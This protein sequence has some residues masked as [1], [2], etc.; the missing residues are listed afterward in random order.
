MDPGRRL[1][2]EIVAVPENP[3]SLGRAIAVIVRPE[4]SRVYPGV[5]FVFVE[6]ERRDT[7]PVDEVVLPEKLMI[8]GA[9]L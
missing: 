9:G 7:C 5:R 6:P 4:R 2:P 1:V 3:R 8:F